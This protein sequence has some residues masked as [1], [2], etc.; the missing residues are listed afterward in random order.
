MDLP[1]SGERRHPGLRDRHD[2]A[3]DRRRRPARTRGRARLGRPGLFGGL[4]AVIPYR[5][6]ERWAWW[7]LWFYPVFWT[8]HLVGGLPPGKDHLHQVAFIALS[9]TGLLLPV[10]TYFGTPGKR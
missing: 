9:L 5:R 7:A 6:R 10:R 4:I 3:A 1:G 8:V 2:P